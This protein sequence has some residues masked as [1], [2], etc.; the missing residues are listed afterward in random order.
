MPIFIPV[1]KDT[2]YETTLDTLDYKILLDGFTVFEGRAVKGPEGNLSINVNRIFKD[3][4]ENRITGFREVDGGIITHPEAFRIFELRDS[5]D[6]LLAT[7]GV[8][9]DWDREW[10]GQAALLSD[11]VRPSISQQMK[12]PISIYS[13]EGQTETIEF[14]PIVTNTYFNLS[15]DSI[16]VMNRGGSFVLQWDTDFYPASD[17]IPTA[18]LGGVTFSNQTSTGVT[19]TVPKSPL[20]GSDRDFTITFTYN[21][22]KIGEATV[23]QTKVQFTLITK[24]LTV[25][26]SGGT[27]N[28]QW[29]TDMILSGISISAAS[30]PGTRPTAVSYTG[31]TISIPSNTSY[32]DYDFVI[33]Y[34]YYYDN[35]GVPYHL[36]STQVTIRGK[37]GATSGDTGTTTGVTIETGVTR[38][39]AFTSDKAFAGFSTPAIQVWES[40]FGEIKANYY[41]RP[42]RNLYSSFVLSYVGGLRSVNVWSNIPLCSYSIECPATDQ[43]N[44][45]TPLYEFDGYT[46]S[47]STQ[48]LNDLLIAAKEDIC[49]DVIPGDR[50]E[51]YEGESPRVATLYLKSG[52]TVLCENT[53]VQLPRNYQW[54]YGDAGAGTERVLKTVTPYSFSDFKFKTSSF[55]EETVRSYLRN[56]IPV[57]VFF[58]IRDGVYVPQVDTTLQNTF[59]KYDTSAFEFEQDGEW[60]TV[61]TPLPIY[62]IVDT[63]GLSATEIWISRNVRYLS[64]LLDT[65]L[66]AVT[67]AGT[68]QDFRNVVFSFNPSKITT[69]QCSDGV[70]YSD[71][72]GWNKSDPINYIGNQIRPSLCDEYFYETDEPTIGNS[73]TITFT[74]STVDT[75]QI[76]DLAI[77]RSGRK[78]APVTTTEGTSGDYATLTLTYDEEVIGIRLL[79]STYR[80]VSDNILYYGPYR[81]NRGGIGIAVP[82]VKMRAMNG[83]VYSGNTVMSGTYESNNLKFIKGTGNFAGTNITTLKAPNL[84]SIM[85]SALTDS[86]IEELYIPSIQW[87]GTDA[88][89]ATTTKVTVGKSFS[90]CSDQ[91]FRKATLLTSLYFNGSVEEWEKLMEF[92]S[93]MRIIFNNSLSNITT[94][95]CDNGEWTPQ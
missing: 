49:R 41:L 46:L 68:V 93:G 75:T 43:T 66:T 33:D 32:D 74:G 95:Y 61:R 83:Y 38:D 58:S 24:T 17:I 39:L 14:A 80:Q 4:I 71:L 5:S 42:T 56:V 15:Q 94:V 52:S 10:N 35:S 13:P 81:E 21:G 92:N 64:G 60:V 59:Q 69:V 16:I 37:A 6:T 47:G 40:S 55:N 85:E 31:A 30:W 1:V 36:D 78:I 57:Y 77:G 53:V 34:N 86:N 87:I 76:N 89:P 23:V 84:L 25:A 18:S 90:D 73:I 20:P 82:S 67:Y 62:G 79:R 12:F 2:Y 28:I 44:Q 27:V 26:S 45:I 8:L 51:R 65:T 54:Y 29:T 9:F 3:Y 70:A 50:Y 19:V 63:S 72:Q 88:L 11:P 7:Y 22:K 91:A 48:W